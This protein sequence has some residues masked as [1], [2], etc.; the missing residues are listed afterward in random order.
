MDGGSSS[1]QGIPPS[2]QTLWNNIL[3]QIYLGMP[4]PV[5]QTI[6]HLKKLIPSKEA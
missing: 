1:G 5:I 6:A 2:V 3:Q 4:V